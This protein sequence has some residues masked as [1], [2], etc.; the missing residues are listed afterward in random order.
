MFSRDLTKTDIVFGI[1]VAVF[2][3]FF[4]Y[5]SAWAGAP[6]LPVGGLFV[7]WRQKK[8]KKKQERELLLQFKECVLSVES[9]LK[10]GYAV[11]NA[12]VESMADME[13]MFGREC[14]M[15][16]ELEK[17]R[18]GLQ[19]NETLENLL[20]NMARV[21][22]LEEIRE[23][24]EVFRIAKRN[25]GNIPQTIELYSRMI[26]EK[27]D[28]EAELETLLAAKLLE[29][30]V[31]NVMPFFLV[32]YL[33]YSNPGYFDGM[34]HNGFGVVIMTGCLVLYLCAYVLSE[35]IFRKA[36]G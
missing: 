34:Y 12:F 33:E 26:T 35:K 13:A 18:Y 32:L 4:F 22:G 10:A 28:L 11:E 6:M 9:S 8:R 29:Q 2:F 24:A 19:N 21:S 30:R 36:Y 23:F 14:Q 1:G 20:Q 16:G 25:S 31:M 7:F 27:L 15:Y 3:A 17:L 5:R